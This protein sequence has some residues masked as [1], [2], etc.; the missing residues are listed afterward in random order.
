MVAN[1]DYTRG[2]PHPEPFLT[3]AKRLGVEPALC[4]ALENSYHG[5]RAASSAGMMT[6]MVPDLM[7]PTSE[8]KERCVHIAADLHEVH[9][10]MR[11]SA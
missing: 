1:G 2:K 7:L 9:S 5:V 10:L 3:A 8:M 6:I 4:L 11:T